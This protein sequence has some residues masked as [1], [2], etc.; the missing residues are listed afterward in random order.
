NLWVK[1]KGR[2]IKNPIKIIEKLD[3]LSLPNFD[4]KNFIH[5]NNGSF[6]KGDFKLFDNNGYLIMTSRG[7]P[8]RCT[9][10]V[11]SVLSRKI[12]STPYKGKYV[13]RRSV[14]HVIDELRLAKEHFPMIKLIRVCDD[15]FSI[16]AKWLREFSVLYK[17]HINIPL[18]C[19]MHINFIN[20]E[21]I[22]SLKHAGLVLCSIG[23]ESGSQRIRYQVYNKFISNDKIFEVVNLLNKNKVKHNLNILMN[24]PLEGDEDLKKGVEFLLTLPRPIHMNFFSLVNF[25]GTDLTERL[26]KEGIIERKDICKNVSNSVSMRVLGKQK[27]KEIKKQYWFYIYNSIPKSFIPKFLIRFFIKDFFIVH[28]KFVINTYKVIYGI[29]NLK[30]RL[31]KSGNLYDS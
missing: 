28:P 26:L 16:D 25:P 31:Y 23:V 3:D 18:W 12:D 13:R 8:C 5:I 2:I 30:D 24:N 21:I 22:D 7:C 4:S 11:H 6:S 19:N 15:I 17:K 29:Y 20:Q 14:K 10:C 1:Q 9:Y 27:L